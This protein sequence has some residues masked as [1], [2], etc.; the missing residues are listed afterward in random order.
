MRCTI[1]IIVSTQN[2]YDFIE[3]VVLLLSRGG[4]KHLTTKTKQKINNHE[5]ILRL[6]LLKPCLYVLRIIQ[7][8]STRSVVYRFIIP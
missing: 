3:D 5:N 8:M 7:K 6:K 4:N 1:I 2:K